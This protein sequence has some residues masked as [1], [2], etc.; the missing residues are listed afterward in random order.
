MRKLLEED[1]FL[2]QQYT[3][4]DSHHWPLSVVRRMTLIEFYGWQA[5]DELKSLEMR[6]WQS[7]RS[8]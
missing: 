8:F 5:F 4:A 1:N 3:L 7:S 2:F 6:K